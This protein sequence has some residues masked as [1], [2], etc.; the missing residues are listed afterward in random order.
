MKVLETELNTFWP[1]EKLLIMGN[2]SFCHNVFQKTS[3]ADAS[4]CVCMQKTGKVK[5]TK[6]LDLIWDL[7]SSVNVY[8]K[9][10]WTNKSK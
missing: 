4:K 10:I 5:D 8:V 1:K 7:P 9:Q 3:V 6:Y 2:C